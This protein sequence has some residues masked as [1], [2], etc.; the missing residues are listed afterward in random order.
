M[1]RIMTEPG[2]EIDFTC[3]VCGKPTQV[4]PDPPARAIC[5]EC[6]EGHEY[7][8]CPH[9]RGWYCEHCDEE[10]PSDH[11]LYSDVERGI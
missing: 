6:C 1:R 8:H 4:A 3:R 2:Q 10:A 11:Y 5:P 9:R 7:E